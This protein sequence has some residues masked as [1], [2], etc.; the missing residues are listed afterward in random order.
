MRRA[1]KAAVDR[2]CYTHFVSY[3][4]DIKNV[5]LFSPYGLK[6]QLSRIIPTCIPNR[7]K[8]NDIVVFGTREDTRDYGY[9]SDVVNSLRLARDLPKGET[10]S[11]ATGQEITNLEMTQEITQITGG[12]SNIVFIEYSKKIGNI[13]AQLGALKKAESLI[14]WGSRG[15]F[16]SQ[17]SKGD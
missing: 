1:S 13:K 8:N 2:V 12:E 17:P 14:D 4:M 5:R 11:L 3:G 9:I 15:K 6:Q 10:I 7:K 16:C